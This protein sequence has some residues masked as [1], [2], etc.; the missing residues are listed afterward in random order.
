M[1]FDGVVVPVITQ[2]DEYGHVDTKGVAEFTDIL[3]NQGVHGLVACGT[4]GEAYA[5][6]PD[7]RHLV[8]STIMKTV[9][10]RVPVLS[11]VGGMATN[12]ALDH[13][14][15]AKRMECAGLMLAAP[16]YS[17]PTDDELS[18][19]AEIVINA[20]GLPTVLY[21]YPQRI[22]VQWTK[23]ALAPLADHPLVL[24]I[25]E[26]SGDLSRIDMLQENFAG[27]IEPVCGADVDSVVF[28]EKGVTSWIGGIGNALP[29]AHLGIMDPATR[30]EAHAAVKP[31]LANIE[32]GR[33][34]AKVK[35]LMGLLGVPS[36]YTRGPVKPLEEDG[37][38][39]LRDLLEQAGDWAPK[40]A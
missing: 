7:E 14:S 13:A 1:Q 17:V 24:G 29:K 39:Q 6:T 26:A 2:F 33:Y 20:A 18:T 38:A 9:A 15:L 4:T 32:S 8:I 40:L 31:L 34:I 30:A 21:D 27:R 25:K 19:H 5:L 36:N 22:G 12:T 37:V 10:G 23:E 28:F 11:G 35:A 16:A 3:V